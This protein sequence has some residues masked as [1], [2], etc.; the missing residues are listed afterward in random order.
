MNKVGILT[1]GQSPR[2]DITPTFKE[3]FH[4]NI[5]IVERGALDSLKEAELLKVIAKKE[6]NITVSRLRDGRSIIISK[7]ELLPLLQHELSKLEQEVDMVIVLC[8]DDFPTLTCEKPIFYPGRIVTQVIAAMA[9][10]PNIGLIVPLEE[11]RRI[12]LNKWKGVT[13]NIT[14]AVASPYDYANFKAA[15]QYLKDYQVDLII[16][17]SMGYNEEH[18]Q[19]VRKESGIITILPRTLIARIVLEYL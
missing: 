18:K 13:N 12:I 5:E 14:V 1:I 16:L 10:Q 9:D 15:A 3:F 8:T 17:D 6:K 2:S 11:Q 4:D 7:R 19:L